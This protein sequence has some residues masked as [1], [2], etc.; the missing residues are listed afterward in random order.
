MLTSLFERRK[1]RSLFR[2][3]NALKISV[4]AALLHPK[5]LVAK[6][7]S[8]WIVSV[9]S[10][11][12]DPGLSLSPGRSVMA[13]PDY[14]EGDCDELIKPKKLINPVKNSRN[15]QDLHRELLMNQKR[16]ERHTL[17]LGFF[18]IWC[19]HPQVTLTLHVILFYRTSTNQFHFIFH[20]YEW[21]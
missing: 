4:F 2:N 20:A 6:W 13:E 15:H 9:P 17:S 1:N 12:C 18:F 8:L 3:K 10:D 21:R 19:G 14:L 5:I 16:S 7:K 11:P